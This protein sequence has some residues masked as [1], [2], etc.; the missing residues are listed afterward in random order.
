M[1]HGL[2]NT[3]ST[4]IFPGA[5]CHRLLFGTKLYCLVNTEQRHMCEQLAPGSA[6][7]RSQTCNLGFTSLARYRYTTEPQQ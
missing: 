6:M 4:V 7:G 2:C 1:T 3:R 5:G